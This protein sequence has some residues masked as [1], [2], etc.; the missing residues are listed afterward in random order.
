MDDEEF[1]KELAE[2]LRPTLQRYEELGWR[3]ID[4]GWP[5][6]SRSATRMVF[7]HATSPSGQRVH[8]IFEDDNDLMDKVDT[9]LRHC[10]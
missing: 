5:T 6:G 2:A 1:P 9:F 3:E 4:F 10:G 7:L 8:A